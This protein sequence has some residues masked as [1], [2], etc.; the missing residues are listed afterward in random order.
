MANDNSVDID[1]TTF[2]SDRAASMKAEADP[3][4]QKK[5]GRPKKEDKKQLTE[6]ITADNGTEVVAP[7]AMWQSNEPYIDTY[8]DSRTLLY[9][10][11]AELDVIARDVKEELTLVKDSKTI[12]NK[13]GII[14]DLANTAANIIGHKIRA[15]QEL[16]SI[17]TKAHDLDMKR[18]KDNK[19]AQLAESQNQDQHIFDMYNAFVNTPVGAYNPIQFPTMQEITMADGMGMNTGLI[20]ADINTPQPGIGDPAY[21][22]YKQRE[23]PEQRMMIMQKNNPNIKTVVVYNQENQTKRFE[24]RDTMTG[25]VIPGA[26]VPADY[27]LADTTINLANGVARNANIDTVYPL[28]VEGNSSSILNY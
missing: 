27:L 4:V 14:N 25:Q 16:D 15:V 22:S 1:F 26:S 13:Y 11:I 24:V 18:Y 2:T 8:N 12:R 6:I 23:T 28:V 17:V 9:G 20:T 3:P 7:L 21:A 5:R 10:S 19:S